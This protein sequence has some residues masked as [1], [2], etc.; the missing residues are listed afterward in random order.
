[1]PGDQ[2]WDQYWHGMHQSGSSA[3]GGANHPRLREFWHEFF[4][5]LQSESDS[6]RMID[7]ASGD[8]AVV[9]FAIETLGEGRTDITCL[10]ISPSAVEIL[11]ERFPDVKGIVA[12]A[13]QTSLASGSFEIVTSQFGIEY[14]GIDAF[15][16]A[17]RLLAPG[18]RLA[19]LVH[20]HSGSIYNEGLAS[21]EA[22]GG[23]AKSEFIPLS[24][25]MFEAGFAACQG[26]DREPYDVAV[27]NLLPAFRQL[28]DLMRTHGTHVA[29]DTLLRLYTDVENI[30]QQMEQ[31]DQTEV[32]GWLKSLEIGLVAYE[33]NMMAMRD[34]ALREAQ[35]VEVCGALEKAGLGLEQAVPLHADDLDL[36]IAWALTAKSGI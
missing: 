11:Q 34:A 26:A 15:E 36:P 27:R 20:Y 30:D 12:D 23:L 4:S 7:L 13:R 35:F 10:E 3:I 19:C 29:G 21:L 24:I 18:G 31:Y 1:M 5:S 8:G 17:A 16:E 9:E 25:A 28:E 6:T 33:S 32:I 22:V 14:A 2:S